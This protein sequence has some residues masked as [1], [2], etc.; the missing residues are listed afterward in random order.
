[1]PIRKKSNIKYYALFASLCVLFYFVPY[2]DDDLRWGCSVGAE[3][4]ATHF[5]GYGGR[6]LGYLLIMA[7]TRSVLF[8]TMFMA[9]CLTILVYLIVKLS[10]WEQSFYVAVIM[11]F[12]MP[13]KLFSSTIA[14]ASGFANYVTS[15]TLFL[16]FVVIARSSIGEK[17]NCDGYKTV[18]CMCLLGSCSTLLVEHFTILCVVSAFAVAIWQYLHERK[19]QPLILG[20]AA[21]CIAGAALM[22]TNSAYLSIVS[23]TDQTEYRNIAG[24]HT[25]GNLV[26]RFSKIYVRGYSQNIALMVFVLAALVVFLIARRNAFPVKTLKAAGYLVAIEAALCMSAIV[27]E[28]GFQTHPASLSVKL[29]LMILYILRKVFL[30]VTIFVFAK[31]DRK[32][33]IALLLIAC[34]FVLDAP[35]L[36][37]EPV[38]KRAFLGS[39][40]LYLTAGCILI[41]PAAEILAKETDA[42]KI[43]ERILAFS[44]AT[45][46]VYNAGIYAVTDHFDRARLNDI[47]KHAAAGKTVIELK[48]LPKRYE[49]YVHD[50]TVKY[51]LALRAYREFYGLPEN[52]ELV[53]RGDKNA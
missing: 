33:T 47:R 52:I 48:H 6:Y 42:V 50:I 38:P 39:F 10:E 4:L 22:F 49:R 53:Y 44:V 13:L 27:I 20:Y 37:I 1:M 17:R 15:I 11:L 3:R 45:L 2:S 14:W 26:G 43:L 9:V 16:A 21:G 40:I 12:V 31:A 5:A 30:L 46:I 51:D 41:R 32:V 25:L 29:L 36:I 34:T 23:G 28:T 35:F 24:T 19:I 7:M 8:K 18:I